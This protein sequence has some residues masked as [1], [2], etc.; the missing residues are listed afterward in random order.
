[1]TTLTQRC[2]TPAV[3][4]VGEPSG[5]SSHVSVILGPV[6]CGTATHAEDPVILTLEGNIH[7]LWDSAKHI[8]MAILEGQGIYHS[9]VTGITG[10][11]VMDL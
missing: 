8:V 4:L 7:L 11:A 5:A 10:L 3:V 9:G 6:L 1:M 2:Y